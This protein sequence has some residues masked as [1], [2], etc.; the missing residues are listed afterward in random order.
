M[1]VSYVKSTTLRFSDAISDLVHV[2]EVLTGCTESSMSCKFSA[3]LKRSPK[4]LKFGVENNKAPKIR[5]Q[6]GLPFNR[7]KYQWLSKRS[8]VI[9]QCSV[10]QH[11]IWKTHAQLTN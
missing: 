10:H 3:P 5:I 8:R 2:L 9:A 6:Q 4:F 7:Y 11:W 1:Y